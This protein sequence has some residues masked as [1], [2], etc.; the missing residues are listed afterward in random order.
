MVVGLKATGKSSKGVSAIS[1][2][3]TRTVNSI[4]ARAIEQG[5]ESFER[6]MRL[7]DRHLEDTSRPV[8]PS[9]QTTVSQKVVDTVRTDRYG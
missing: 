6:P 9:K 5:F 1:G 2:I 3:L 7:L 8:R 4:Y